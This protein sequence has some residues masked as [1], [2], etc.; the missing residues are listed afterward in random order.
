MS[1]IFLQ[2][3]ILLISIQLIILDSNIVTVSLALEMEAVRSAYA[4][5]NLYQIAWNHILGE[6]TLRG[7]LNGVNVTVH[8]PIISLCIIADALTTIP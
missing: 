4:S 6:K 2:T 1:N 5:I 3:S 8:Y 7:L